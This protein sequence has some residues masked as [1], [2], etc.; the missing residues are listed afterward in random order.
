MGTPNG[1][2][3][4]GRAGR[5]D[6]TGRIA[7]MPDISIHR[8]KQ[9]AARILGRKVTSLSKPDTGTFN[10]SF[11]GT[12]A[13]DNGTGTDFLIQI[14]PRNHVPLQFYERNMLLQEPRLHRLVRRKT[15]IPIADILYLDASGRQFGAPVI[16]YRLLPG[17]PMARVKNADTARITRQLGHFLRQLHHNVR[18]RQFGYHGPHRPMPPKRTWPDAFRLIWRKFLDDLVAIGAY[19][20]DEADRYQALLENNLRHFN[21]IRD[22]SLLHMD[23]WEQNIL[24]DGHEITGIIDWD[25]ALWGDPELEL[26]V[27]E[28]SHLLTPAFWKGYG[29]RPVRSRPFQIRRAFYILY[30][31]QKHIFG[32]K[33]REPHP[34]AYK[35]HLVK[36][37][38]LFRKMERGDFNIRFARH[39]PI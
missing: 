30:E 5:S 27:I 36:C 33:V 25:R 23:I 34:R 39:K 8:V 7:A 31:H 2:G 19:S 24:T 35:E 14:A 38:S 11:I 18:G 20:P 16:I 17:K 29:R 6:N 4:S 21:H 32:Y 10:T 3:R 1:R 26:A 9:F 15:D 28:K 37:R 13:G 22:A 12:L